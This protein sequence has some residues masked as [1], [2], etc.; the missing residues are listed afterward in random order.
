[1]GCGLALPNLGWRHGKGCL[2]L[3]R[4]NRLVLV[5]G[6]EPACEVGRV[7]GGVSRA[8]SQTVRLQHRA[9]W[10]SGGDAGLLQ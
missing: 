5:L 10:G 8:H 9:Y 6:T 4:Q 3:L 7:V 1:M 2:P